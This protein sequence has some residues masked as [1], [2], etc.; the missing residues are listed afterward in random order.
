M[1]N[2]TGILDFRHLLEGFAIIFLPR[3]QPA[4]LWRGRQRGVLP[5][6]SVFQTRVLGLF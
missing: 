2:D 1:S 5:K 6:E 4:K 3:V